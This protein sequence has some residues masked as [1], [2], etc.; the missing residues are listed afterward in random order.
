MTTQE[1]E[2]A[3]VTGPAPL[4]RTVVA[5]F[6]S[7]A[8][9]ALLATG[10]ELG[11]QWDLT[12]AVTRYQVQHPEIIRDAF[13]AYAHRDNGTGGVGSAWLFLGISLSF[14]AG[15]IVCLALASLPASRGSRLRRGAV[16]AGIA[17]V[18][19]SVVV[20]WLNW[21]LLALRVLTCQG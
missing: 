19:L 8:L 3:I 20:F 17:E 2:I 15:G 16:A 11:F 18:V 14:A 4:S 10:F 7:A 21:F 6:C 5:A 1:P 9:G 12:N 13:C